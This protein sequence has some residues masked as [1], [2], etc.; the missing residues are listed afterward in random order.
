MFGRTGQTAVDAHRVDLIGG[1]LPR[2]GRR[3]VLR[4]RPMELVGYRAT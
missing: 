4:G 2:R 3:E 1:A